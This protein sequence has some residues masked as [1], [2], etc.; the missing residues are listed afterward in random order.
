MEC[1]V[2]G[3]P[4]IFIPDTGTHPPERPSQE[5]PGSDLIASAPVSDVS[6]HVCTNG[7]WPL[8]RP[9]SVAQ[10]NIPSVSNP[11]TSPWTAWPDGSGPQ[12]NGYS[13]P[14]PRSSAAKQWLEQLAQKKKKNNEQFN[15]C[16]KTQGRRKVLKDDEMFFKDQGIT[17]GVA[18]PGIWGGQKNLGGPKCL[19]LG[20]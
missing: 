16:V 8:L 11:L 7:V 1:G 3:Q 18:S 13:T 20:E 9:V 12:S 19:I 5:E 4:H 6:V 17:S 14:V 15:N 2:G 10:K